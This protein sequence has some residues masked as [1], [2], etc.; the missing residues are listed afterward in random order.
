[1]PQ[2]PKIKSLKKNAEYSRLRALFALNKHDDI[3]KNKKHFV[4]ATSEE[5]KP[6][7]LETFAKSHIALGEIDEGLGEMIV[8]LEEGSLLK[9]T[10][11][12]IAKAISDLA[13]EHKK[14]EALSFSIPFLE[15]DFD[16]WIQARFFKALIHS[17][18]KHFLQAKKELTSLL[19]EESPLKPNILSELIS[20]LDQMKD[21]E[22][23]LYFSKLFLSLFPVHKNAVLVSSF[24]V[25]ASMELSDCPEKKKEL[26]NHPRK[27]DR[28]TLHE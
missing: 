10:E 6:F 21:F 7:V 9:E 18:K 27:V 1:M 28:F 22:E 16:A 23:S 12:E 24:F 3:L 11:I 8:A 2:K 26:L 15:K 25:S 13:F 5:Q 4:S 19:K 14:I 20:I 17:E